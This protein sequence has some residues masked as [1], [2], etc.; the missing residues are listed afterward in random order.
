MLS[1]SIPTFALQTVVYAVVIFGIWN[2]PVAR[3]LINP[4]KLF[5]IGWHEFCHIVAVRLSAAWLKHTVS[6]SP[7][8]S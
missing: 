5:T 1:V 4:L 7:S 6:S 2:I 8:T 3:T